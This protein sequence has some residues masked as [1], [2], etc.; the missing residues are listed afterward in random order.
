[1]MTDDITFCLNSPSCANKNCFR[2]ES[3]IRERTIP[4]SFAQMKGTDYCPVYAKGKVPIPPSL[5]LIP[6]S[7][8][9]VP[10]CGFCGEELTTE[11]SACESCGTK[12]DWK[13]FDIRR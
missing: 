12:I 13:A 11:I 4:H 10:I 3:N 8:C 9:F 2:H 1:M 6:F 7:N 5:R